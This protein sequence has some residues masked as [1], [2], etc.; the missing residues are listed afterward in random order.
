[1]LGLFGEEL[2]EVGECFELERIACGIEE[3]HL[4]PARRLRP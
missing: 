2:A 4:W 1:M 3:E